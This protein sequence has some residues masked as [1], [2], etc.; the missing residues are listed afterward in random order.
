[1]NELKLRYREESLQS[2][3]DVFSAAALTMFQIWSKYV[4]D[5][6]LFWRLI[7]FP[8]EA[9][10]AFA[11][12]R[13]PDLIVD[14]EAISKLS[15]LNRALDD[16]CDMWLIPSGGKIRNFVLLLQNKET[17]SKVAAMGADQNGM[18]IASAVCR[19]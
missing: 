9:Q 7:V 16:W 18:P 19:V 5:V 8:E 3:W 2:P 4:S 11:R 6:Q 12:F 15:M 1:M 10:S 17:S 14:A 13:F